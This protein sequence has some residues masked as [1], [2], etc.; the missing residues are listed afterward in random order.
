MLDEY[1]AP[2]LILKVVKC[3]KYKPA[4]VD[5]DSDSDYESDVEYVYDTSHVIY[6]DLHRHSSWM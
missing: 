1:D 5:F 3:V 2:T 4:T 6:S